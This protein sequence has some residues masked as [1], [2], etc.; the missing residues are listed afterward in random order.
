MTSV[1]A[2]T[3]DTPPDTRHGTTMPEA[4][5]ALDGFD[6]I[7]RVAFNGPETVRVFFDGPSSS[8][9]E[10][11]TVRVNGV[12]YR[13]SLDL[14]RYANGWDLTNDHG[15]A[16]SSMFMTRTDRWS[17]DDASDAARRKVRTV[18]VPAIAAWLAQNDHYREAGAVA[19]AERQ[20]DRAMT[21]VA[22]ASEAYAEAVNKLTA[23]QE[24]LER[25]KA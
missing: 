24:A 3:I 22:E 7:G 19:E 16:Y 11:S 4:H 15:H 8:F 9:R 10:T 23:A 14:T 20:V 21:K 17:H 6:A 25:V 18:I 5:I 2:R 1:I 13:L 12:P